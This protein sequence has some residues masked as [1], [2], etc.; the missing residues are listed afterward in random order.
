MPFEHSEYSTQAMT[1]PRS[2]RIDVA[3]AHRIDLAETARTIVGFN[4]RDERS[5]PFN[6]LRGQ[7]LR[8]S[9][10]RDLRVIAVTSATPKVGK[11]FVAANL[12]ASVARLPEL[13]TYLF[14]LDLRRSSI[15]ENFEIPGDVGLTEFLDGRAD[16]LADVAW[17]VEGQNLTIFP[18]FRQKVLSSELL[19]GT[20]MDMLIAAMRNAPGPAMCVC[21][22][23]PVFANDDAVIISQKVD[24]YILII[25]EGVTTAKQVRDSMRMLEPALCLGTVLNRYYGGFAGDDYGYG[26]GRSNQY[27]DYY[28]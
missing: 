2:L 18:S 14:D 24:G 12:A 17:A 26:Y 3:P 4:S 9:K 22:L 15:A 27:S 19:A 11:S 23:P 6:L 8:L 16:D 25:E 1:A 10:V 7:L 28:N 13:K 20:R 21:D 5:R